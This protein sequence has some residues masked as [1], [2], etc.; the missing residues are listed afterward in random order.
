VPHGRGGLTPRLALFYNSRRVDGIRSWVQ[1]DWAGLGWS[2]DTVEIVRKLTPSSN[3]R[4]ADSTYENRFTL[5][6]N[7][8]AYKLEPENAG[9]YYGRYHTADEQF[10]FIERRNAPWCA[11][12]GGCTPDEEATNLT[13]EYWLVQAKDGTVYRLGYYTDSEQVAVAAGLYAWS[14]GGAPQDEW[15]AGEVEDRVAFRWRLDRIVDPQ[16]NRIE[17]HYDE[18]QFGYDTEP[19]AD[20][21]RASYLYEVCYN[22]ILLAGG[23]EQCGNRVL[24]LRGQRGA[25]PDTVPDWEGDAYGQGPW[26]FYFYQ[27]DYLGSIQVQFWNT[28]SL[29]YT[30]LS[31]YVLTYDEQSQPE[32]HNNHTRRLKRITPY[33]RGGTQ[34]GQALPATTFDYRV[35][36]NK[37]I[38]HWFWGGACTDGLHDEWDQEAFRYERLSGVDSGYGGVITTTYQ[39]P[40]GSIDQ[41]YWQT[42]NYRVARRQTQDRGAVVR[43]VAYAYPDDVNDRCYD[44]NDDRVCDDPASFGGGPSGGQLVGYK[45]V[46]ETLKTGAGSN[47]AI[48]EHDFW[49][50]DVIS[51]TFALGRE[52]E[53][54]VIGPAD[55]TP[56]RTVQRSYTDDTAGRPAGVHF[57][58]L[59]RVD[60]YAG[61]TGAPHT[62]TDYSYAAYGN[63]ARVVEYGNVNVAGDERTTHYRYYPPRRWHPLRRRSRGAGIGVRRRAPER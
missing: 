57:I 12:R 44:E 46:T 22:P 29:T 62:Q 6:F 59:D 32:G 55:P 42:K 5:L 27:R 8:A 19:P 26:R 52:V 17:F 3:W 43:Q 47:V 16:G 2:V 23:A 39:T 24:F 60:T 37:G 18:E 13:Q 7:G 41:G 10:L 49:L 35:Y 53:T 51:P 15:Y 50:R 14:G 36:P 56:L 21:D 58:R 20:R 31:E 38:C 11:N 48:T 9:Q 40:D 25:A 34:T 63:T 28:N 54:R 4:W 1:A 45:T 33:G 61:D 30:I